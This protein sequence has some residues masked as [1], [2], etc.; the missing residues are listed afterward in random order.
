MQVYFYTFTKKHNSTKQPPEAVDAAVSAVLKDGTSLLSPVLMLDFDN[1]PGALN[2]AYIPDFERYYFV[3]NWEYNRGVWFAYLQCDALASWKNQIL[4][5]EAYVLRSFAESNLGITDTYYPMLAQASAK[6]SAA[7]DYDWDITEE[8]GSFVVGVL[9]YDSSISQGTTYYSMTP[10]EF[11]AF[12]EEAFGNIDYLGVS[13]IGTELLKALFNPVQYITSVVWYPFT[14]PHG[15]LRR[16][17]LGWWELQ[18]TAGVIPASTTLTKSWSFDIPKNA[19]GLQGEYLNA[20]PYSYYQLMHPLCGVVP[21]NS[22]LLVLANTLSVS[23]FIDVP[24]GRATGTI[25]ATGVGVSNP[26]T[27]IAAQVGCPVNISQI[28]LGLSKS[29][30]SLS[31]SVSSW[32]TNTS[33]LDVVGAIASGFSDMMPSVMSTGD[34]G[35]MS[36]YQATPALVL[37]YRY[38][39]SRWD[40]H[41]GRPLCER[42]TLRDLQ[43]GYVLCHDADVEIAGTI[44]EQDSI[45]SYLNKGCFLE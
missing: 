26:I 25:V 38:T 23:W 1:Y 42:K 10:A 43:Y 37:H 11:A 21:L 41:F 29:A 14:V 45:N 31:S 35:N 22:A 19:E 6:T 16:I 30:N 5:S 4:A 36:V 32:G 39:A 28:T 2:Y 8:E 40:D 13:E 9:C 27:N 33:L 18:A 12:R 17:K 44:D 7:R 20:E 15:D 24:S 3:T 34:S